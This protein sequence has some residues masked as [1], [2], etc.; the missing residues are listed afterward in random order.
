MVLLLTISLLGLPIISGN[1]ASMFD[2]SKIDPNG[3]F[4]WISVHHIAQALFFIIFIVMIKVAIKLIKQ[5]NKASVSDINFGFGLGNKKLG[6]KYISIFTA[7]FLVYTAIGFAIAL[8]TKTFNPPWYPINSRNVFGYLG[9]QLLLSGP[10]EEILF[11][12][13][14]I[15]MLALVWNKRI[16]KG[17]LSVAN[18]VLGIIFGLAHIGI[19]FSPFELR[20]SLFQ[21]FYAFA[22]GLVYGDCFE[23]TGSVY[24]PMA[25]HSISNVI[26]VGA[27]IIVTLLV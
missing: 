26:A 2:Y 11:R 17:K 27:T 3:V 12:S 25:L 6:I 13:F 15:T 23:K 16:F 4:M 8:F 20:Y 1:I 7:A 5:K 9:F 10:S 14:G 24:Y 21:V 18:L 22:L 19:Y